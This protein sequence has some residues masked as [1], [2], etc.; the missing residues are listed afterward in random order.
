MFYL[1]KN[2]TLILFHLFIIFMIYFIINNGLTQIKLDSKFF[3][4]LLFI[5][6]CSSIFSAIVSNRNV[7]KHIWRREI[8]NSIK[9][10]ISIYV[11]IIFIFSILYCITFKFNSISITTLFIYVGFCMIYM[12]WQSNILIPTKHATIQRLHHNTF[13][14]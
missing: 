12:Y 1:A 4:S 13:T 2:K 14:T 7:N 11:I 10:S 8:I 3:I 5:L 6:L 9:F